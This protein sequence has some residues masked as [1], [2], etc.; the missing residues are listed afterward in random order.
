[1]LEI[2]KC[3]YTNS[4]RKFNPMYKLMISFIALIVSI[5]TNNINLHLIIM[6]IISIMIIFW[7]K[8]DIKLYIRCL[9]IPIYFLFIGTILNLISISFEN[10]GFLLNIKI[11]GIYIGTTEFSIDNSIHILL[12]ALS[13]I[14]SIY[15]LILTTPFN[16]LIIILKKMYIPDVLIELMILT[17]R[18][19][20]LFLEE[21]KDIYKSQQLKFG[22]N[23]LKNSYNSTSLLIKV[24]FFRMMKK[25]E[26]MSV[27]LDIKLYDGKFHI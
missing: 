1:M 26:E 5:I 13:C 21:I 25:Y 20:F 9:K 8:V 17:Y 10:T 15:F 23:N 27:T 16:Q 12:R 19:I 22:Y 6:I 18:F 2:D 11:F 7:A 14:I 24:L 3:A 4:L